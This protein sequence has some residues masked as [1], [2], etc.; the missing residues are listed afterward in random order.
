M[1]VHLFNTMSRS[2]ERFKP[3]QAYA[4]TV[5]T[6]GPTIYNI[7]HLG[8][9]RTY[10]FEDVLVRTLRYFDYRPTH[11]M[12]LTDID[13]KTIRESQNAG[14]SLFDFTEKYKKAFLEDMH[15]LGIRPADKIVRV[16][17]YQDR[18]RTMTQTLLDKGFAYV[19][20]DGIYFSLEK[21]PEYGALGHI[22]RS[23]LRAGARIAQDEFDK[24]DAGDFVLWKFYKD[25]DGPVSYDAVFVVNGE[26]KVFP[27]R[28]GWHMECSA[29]IDTEFGSQVDIHC[30]GVDNIFPHHD[31]E[32]AQSECCSGKKPFAKY[33]VH[34]EH[35]MVEGKKMS[36]SLGNF[37][38]L[39]DWQAKGLSPESF[40][41]LTQ[42][43]HYRSPMNLVLDNAAGA[44]Q[45]LRRLHI[46]TQAIVL[47]SQ[48]QDD[49]QPLSLSAATELSTRQ[50]EVFE[51]ILDDLATPK[52]WALIW[53]IVKDYPAESLS[54]AQAQ[55]LVRMCESF[56]ALLGFETVFS[57]IQE[58]EAVIPEAVQQLV[59]RRV[60]AKQARDYTTADALRLEIQQAGY[61]IEDHKDGSSSARKM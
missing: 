44:Q 48:A 29:V 21:F 4:A 1:D 10:L 24:E 52:A 33:W 18:M 13:D 22:D 30:G 31:C 11:V 12:N 56:A 17:E 34:G 42:Q 14:E 20:E 5:Y 23:L 25:S 40:R 41:Y 7:A 45:A 6:C 35:L 53:A 47:R 55:V 9:L 60:A 49:D 46:W 61:D 38:T 19:G 16:T 8:N 37:L 59:Q 54:R 36:K 58:V 2:V 26:Q 39:R 43:V 28:P 50:S 32:I 27:G 15:A 57:G 3:R 51:A